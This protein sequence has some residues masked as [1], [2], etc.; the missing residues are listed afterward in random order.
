MATSQDYFSKSTLTP[1]TPPQVTA[2][3]KTPSKNPQFKLR[4]NLTAET[5]S[6]VE[7]ETEMNFETVEG[8]SSKRRR[9]S[10]GGTKIKQTKFSPTVART[11]GNSNMEL[12]VY[13]KGLDFNLAAETRRHPQVILKALNDACGITV[14]ASNSKLTGENIRIVCESALHRDKFLAVTELAGRTIVA[15]RPWCLERLTGGRQLDTRQL[16]STQVSSAQVNAPVESRRAANTE[17]SDSLPEEAAD[18]PGNRVTLGVVYGVPTHISTEQP[19]QHLSLGVVYGVPV[20]V[21]TDQLAA[22]NN[23]QWARC[24]T[25]QQQPTAV[26]PAGAQ[27]T[28][29]SDQLETLCRLTTLCIGSPDIDNCHGLLAPQ[30]ARLS[31]EAHAV[32]QLLGLR[33]PGQAL[34]EYCRL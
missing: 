5:A 10:D 8:K 14:N 31:A 16:T 17:S 33:S 26:D 34:Q 27:P 22:D 1:R 7:T 13:L 19:D 29:D 20:H 23:C 4:E 9:S 18:G 6:S 12:T 32:Q 21:S 11:A 2:G 28:T 25:Q 24:L 30:G 3:T 15:S